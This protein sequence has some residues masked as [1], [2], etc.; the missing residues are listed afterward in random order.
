MPIEIAEAKDKLVIEYLGLC[1]QFIGDI[2][3]E[4]KSKIKTRLNEIRK[5]LNMELI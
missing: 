2:S 1:R 5:S 4:Q 3:T